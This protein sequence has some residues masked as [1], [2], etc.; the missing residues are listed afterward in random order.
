VL[1]VDI[2]GSNVKKIVVYDILGNVVMQ[3]ESRN[4][5]L[6][7]INMPAGVYIIRATDLNDDLHIG[8]IIKQ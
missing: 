7:L 1:H 4:N 6:S 8:K 5:Q 3:D 2:K